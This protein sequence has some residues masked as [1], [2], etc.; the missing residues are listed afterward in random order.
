[1]GRGEVDLLILY[2]VNPAHDYPG[3]EAFLKA[4]ERVPLSISFAD[5]VDETA[6]H[7]HAVCPDHHYL[8]AW[9][10]AEPVTGCFSLAQPTIA[11]LFDTR[12]AQESLLAWIGE[13]PDFHANL[14][15]YWRQH[16]YPYQGADDDFETFWD[17]TLQA[18]FLQVPVAPHWK[19]A[20]VGDLD[21]VASRI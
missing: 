11:P 4:L 10:D 12:A 16:L 20:F 8:E 14:R 7:V 9:G 15:A 21:T 17:R 6:A 1:M 19:P 18:G 3:S 2:G 13:T 5:R